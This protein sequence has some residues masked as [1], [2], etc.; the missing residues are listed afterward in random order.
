MQLLSRFWI[1]RCLT[2]SLSYFFHNR[3]L[4]FG[5]GMSLLEWVVPHEAKF[6]NIQLKQRRKAFIFMLKMLLEGTFPHLVWLLNTG[7]INRKREACF[8]LFFSPSYQITKDMTQGTFL[9]KYLFLLVF[10][11]SPD[12]F[13]KLNTFCN[14]IDYFN[15]VHEWYALNVFYYY[16]ITS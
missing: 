2:S 5:S 10:L 14:K 12:T 4:F 8:V 15:L 6:L 7:E 11:I 13:D 3:G 1:Y 9:Y 16:Y